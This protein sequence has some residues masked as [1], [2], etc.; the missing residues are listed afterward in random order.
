VPQARVVSL[1]EVTPS[2]PMVVPHHP[3]P[4]S[5]V[6]PL[7]LQPSKSMR[8]LGTPARAKT[9]DSMD[10]ALATPTTGASTYAQVTATPVRRQPVVQTPELRPSTDF[11]TPP[12]AP[13]AER[14]GRELEEDIQAAIAFKSVPLVSFALARGAGCCRCGRGHVLHAAIAKN[15]LAALEFLLGNEGIGGNI[16]DTCGGSTPLHRAARAARVEGDSGHRMMQLLLQHGAKLDVATPATPLHEAAACTR[17]AAAHLLLEHGA[18]PNAMDSQGRTPLHLVCAKA[19]YSSSI[20][21]DQLAEL[22]LKHGAD[23]TWRDAAGL[24]PS[25]HIQMQSPAGRL[26]ARLAHAERSWA[27]RCAVLVRGKGNNAHVLCRLPK[28]TFSAVVQFL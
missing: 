12:P 2:T 10:P 15:H 1:P 4:A 3:P 22:L 16:N 8:L 27:Q 5:P 19:L 23:P 14:E 6:T 13:C 20:L 24:K 7:A 25:E 18:N 11:H 26:D 28:D 21:H 9:T 17:V